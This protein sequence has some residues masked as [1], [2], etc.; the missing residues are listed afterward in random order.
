[1]QEFY[2]TMQNKRV[3]SKSPNVNLLRKIVRTI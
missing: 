2:M 1:M 3:V